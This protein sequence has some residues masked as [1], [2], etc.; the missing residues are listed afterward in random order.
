MTEYLKNGW[1]GLRLRERILVFTAFLICLFGLLHFIFASPDS[2]AAGNEQQSDYMYVDWGDPACTY[3]DFYEDTNW[4]VW[5]V[6][7]WKDHGEFVT[8]PPAWEVSA[9]ATVNSGSL[10]ID[11][12]RARFGQDDA[13]FELGCY[14][15]AGASLYLSLYNSNDIVVLTDLYGDIPPKSGKDT[16]TL[17]EIPF[18]RYPEAVGISIC[19][20]SGFIR[21]YDSLL[22]GAISQC[23]G[24]GRGRASERP[25]II[26]DSA[27]DFPDF[28]S[29]AVTS[30][31]I[32]AQYR[33]L[34][35]DSLVAQAKP[36]D[37]GRGNNDKDDD[38]KLFYFLCAARHRD[39]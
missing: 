29:P 17:F 38:K 36:Q 15:A 5:A 18:E 37:K 1:K 16:R 21:V 19:R 28:F 25:K 34:P 26:L 9:F 35:T 6:S 12:D 33:L 22:R 7:A 23:P 3:G 27:I 30:L 14:G 8:S 39:F 2:A 31:A 20:G 11:I 4:P 24:L 10:N 32:S 13:V